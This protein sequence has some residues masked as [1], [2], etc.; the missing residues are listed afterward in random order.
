MISKKHLLRPLAVAALLVAAG[1]AQA[2]L[3]SYN[4]SGSFL[5]ALSASGTDTFLGFNITGTTPNPITRNAGSFGYTADVGP[6]GFF[7]GAGTTAD[8]YLSTN[9]ATDTITFN[10]FTGGSVSGIG[11]NFFGSNISGLYATGSVT[12]VVT[13]SL[14]A[15]LTTTISPTAALT[16]SYLGFTSDGTIT[17]LTVSAVQGTSPLWP[18]VDNLT[19]GTVAAIPEPGTYALFAAGLAALGFLARRRRG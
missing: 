18:T 19:L 16:G 2:A 15:T 3:T 7:F 13:D 9:T 11:G 10:A 5:A 4:S 14:G 8:P 1:G 12:V 17:S 6:A